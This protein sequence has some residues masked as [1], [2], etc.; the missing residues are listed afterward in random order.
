MQHLPRR[1][2]MAGIPV[3]PS[4]FDGLDP[5]RAS[6]AELLP[7]DHGK[8]IDLDPPGASTQ[9]GAQPVWYATGYLYSPYTAAEHSILAFFGFFWSP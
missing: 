9:P 2:A 6:D 1:L 7:P 5:R 8:F 3:P 4:C